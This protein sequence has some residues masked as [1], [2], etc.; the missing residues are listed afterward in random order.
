[1]RFEHWERRLSA[2][3]ESGARIPFQWGVRD[4]TLFAADC[5]WALTQRDPAAQWRGACSD[6]LGARKIIAKAGG[7]ERLVETGL[8][9]I[10]VPIVRVAPAFGQRGDPCLFDGPLGDTLG[11]IEGA[12]L[13]AQA[14]EG[15]HRQPFNTARIVWAIR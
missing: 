12:M 10:G 7:L 1:M 9:S 6:E 15:L 2:L 13:V 3:I 14:P 11:I 4:C 5:V 8:R